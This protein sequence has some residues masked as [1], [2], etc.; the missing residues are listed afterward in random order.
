VQSHHLI[1]THYRRV[2]NK[3][4]ENVAELSKYMGTLGTIQN[5][6]YDEM[7]SK[8]NLGNICCHP[9]Q[10]LYCHTSY[11]K[12][13]RLKCTRLLYTLSNMCVKLDFPL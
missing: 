10:N 12:T 1:A 6:I 11:L 2:A 8:L 7:R 4:F 13:L 5:N 3:S 9:L